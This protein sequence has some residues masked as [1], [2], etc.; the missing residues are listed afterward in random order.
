MLRT[1][2]F[3]D[4]KSQWREEEQGLLSHDMCVILDEEKELIYFWEGL[5]SNRKRFKEAYSQL[6][7]LLSNFPELNIQLILTKKNFPE[8]IQ[9]KIEDLLELARIEEKGGLMFSRFTTIRTFL[10]FSLG[11]IIMPI[12]SL[13]NLFTALFWPSSTLNV[14]VISTVF[15]SWLNISKIFIIL[16]IIFFAVNLLIGIIEI[17][18]QVIIFSIIGLIICI[19]LIFYLNFDIFLFLFQSGST[20]TNYFILKSDIIRFILFNLVPIIIFEIPNIYKFISFLI[21]YRKYIF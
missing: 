11:V 20:Q 17:E 12:I 6:K 15:R 21:T 2:I 19:G 18:P 13:L 3:D 9:S 7:R 8:E 4:S 16:T 1:F 5:K 10:I 14:E